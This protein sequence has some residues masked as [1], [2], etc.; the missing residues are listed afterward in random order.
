MVWSA[1]GGNWCVKNNGTVWCASYRLVFL[2]NIK[3]DTKY[4]KRNNGPNARRERRCL[5]NNFTLENNGMRKCV[6]MPMRQ[7]ELLGNNFFSLFHFLFE[8]GKIVCIYERNT[9]IDVVEQRVLLSMN[10]ET[11]RTSIEEEN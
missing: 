5:A 4:Q 6:C 9:S 1:V 11:Y 8:W 10:M 2:L 3:K 7:K